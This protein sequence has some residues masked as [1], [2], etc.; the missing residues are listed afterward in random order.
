MFDPFC[1]ALCGGGEPLAYEK[2]TTVTWDGQPTNVFVQVDV[3][4]YFYQVSK[5]TPSANDLDG[6]TV[7]VTYADGTLTNVINGNSAPTWGVVEEAPGMLMFTGMEAPTVYVVDVS[8]LSAD[9]QGIFPESGI[10]CMNTSGYYMSNL[11]WGTVKPI[12]PK[13]I[14]VMDSVTLNS[15]GGKKFAVTVDDSGNLTAT[16]VIL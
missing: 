9:M 6:A 14:P 1:L 13:F 2:T 3:G 16:E 12:D 11:T 10:Y 8:R 5:H 7:E 15:P 4:V